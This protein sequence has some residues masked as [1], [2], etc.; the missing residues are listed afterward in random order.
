MK[1]KEEIL[2]ELGFDSAKYDYYGH[3]FVYRVDKKSG[4]TEMYNPEEGWVDAGCDI[5]EQYNNAFEGMDI[6]IITEETN[7]LY[8]QDLVGM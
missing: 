7:E 5:A 2:K 6:D 4:K 1:N 8:L 3:Y